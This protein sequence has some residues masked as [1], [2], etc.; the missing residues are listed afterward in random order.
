MAATLRILVGALAGVALPVAA[1][2]T[3]ALRA[4]VAGT[5]L[6]AGYAQMINLSAMPDL[7][8]AS[9]RID[10]SEPEAK[11][12]VLHLPLRSPLARPS[13][14]TSPSPTWPTSPAGACTTL[15]RW[16]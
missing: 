14:S 3:D 10:S 16:G 1:Q 9:Y 7:S 2:S 12:D 4:T 15:S 5:R 11:L 8:A 6:G 13:P